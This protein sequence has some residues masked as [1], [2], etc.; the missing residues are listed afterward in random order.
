MS[1]E[2]FSIWWIY[3]HVSLPA[4]FFLSISLDQLVPLSVSLS[5]FF[6]SFFPKTILLACPQETS[7]RAGE[8]RH[9]TIWQP[10]LERFS[11]LRSDVK[12]QKKSLSLS[13]SSTDE[14]HMQQA[15]PR[16]ADWKRRA[17]HHGTRLPFLPLCLV[18]FV[19]LCSFFWVSKAMHCA[20]LCCAV[21]CW[22]VLCC[23]ALQCWTP[24]RDCD[25]S[26]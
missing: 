25:T 18:W 15:M 2:F 4:F 12:K 26:L 1:W 5:V 23:T 17:V 19:I 14:I 16:G 13:L 24:M 9:T 11:P 22:A 8:G 20:V 10:P 3:L 7:C 6:S 21:L